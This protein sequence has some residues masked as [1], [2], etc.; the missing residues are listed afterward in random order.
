M[1]DRSIKLIKF[2]LKNYAPF[3]E[4][5]GLKYFSFD[6]STSPNS[7]V[8][9]LAGNGVGKTYLLSELTPEPFESQIG[10]LTNRFIDNEEGEKNLTYLVDDC[11][12]YNCKIIYS[13]DRRKTTC[14]FSKK[15]GDK[16]EELNLKIWISDTYNGNTNYQGSLIVI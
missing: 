9:I 3:Y 4:S 2:S 6:R 8:L 5:M 11:I 14:F 13:A 15:I 7:I 16:E 1:L 10:R 12:E